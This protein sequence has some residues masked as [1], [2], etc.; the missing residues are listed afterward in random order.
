MSKTTTFSKSIENILNRVSRRLA[1]KGAKGYLSFEKALRSAD[2]D[3]DSLV[4]LQEFKKV[5][6]DQRID[7][8]ETEAHMVF[9]VF[10][11]EA[12]G[13]MNYQELV[14]SVKGTIDETRRR[15][16]NRVW[17]KVKESETITTFNR[18]RNAFNV[19]AHPDIRNGKRYEEEI[20]KE[21]NETLLLVQ[22]L[23]GVRSE[24]LTRDDFEEYL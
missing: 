22:D 12:T 1:A 2:L 5:V 14:N 7:I 18:V 11:P 19:R 15:L 6:R 4:N 9:E 17:D 8:S 20:L 24:E 23:N 10:D 3:Q 13:L 21:L 16:I